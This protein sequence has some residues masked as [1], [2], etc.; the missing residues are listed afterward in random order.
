MFSWTCCIA[1]ALVKSLTA[2]LVAEYAAELVEPPTMPATD[3]MLIIESPPAR[4]MAGIAHFVPMKT[5]LTLIAMMSSQSSSD[6]SSIL[7]RMVTPALFTRMF[8][9][10]Y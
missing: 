7:R 8:S 1:A 9:L 2:P 6:V 5:P 10:P 3:E 4:R